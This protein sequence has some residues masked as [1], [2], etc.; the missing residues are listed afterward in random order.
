MKILISSIL[1]VA[2]LDAGIF[3]YTQKTKEVK[4]INSFRET[5][6]DANDVIKRGNYNRYNEYKDGIKS[7]IDH[8]QRLNISKEEKAE[9]EQDLK[10]YADIINTMYKKLHKK[11]PNF[12]DHYDSSIGELKNF[13]KK[14][15]SIG[16]RPLLSTWYELS[17]I[18]ARFI[19]RPS[20][21]LE[22]K[23]NEHYDLIVNYITELYLDEEIEEPLFAYLKNY[24][25]YFDDINMAYKSVDYEN[26]KKIKPLSYRI[27]AKME[28]MNPL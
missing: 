1:I 23:F 7:T 26:I 28:F 8:V 19:K 12:K 21:K 17:K 10:E 25:A 18:K 20:E 5:I 16:Y 2:S 15:I 13:N 11:A 9:L 14:L 27:K 22:K 4:I 3:D 24:R 6:S